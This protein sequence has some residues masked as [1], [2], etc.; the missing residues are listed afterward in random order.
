[1]KTGVRWIYFSLLPMCGHD[2][3]RERRLIAGYTE[4]IQRKEFVF[5]IMTGMSGRYTSENGKGHWIKLEKILNKDKWMKGREKK[6][7]PTTK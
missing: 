4:G 1:M 2:S 5:W 6:L 3:R 7:R